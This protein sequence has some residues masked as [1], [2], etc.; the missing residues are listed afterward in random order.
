MIQR[1][2]PKF[3]FL[4]NVENL[5]RHEK[6]S[7]FRT[8][9]NTLER[10]LGYKVIGVGYNLQGEPDYDPSDF[11]R[12][13]KEFGIP[14]NR[15]RVYIIAFNRRYFGK[16]L[17]LIPNALPCSR[18][19]GPLYEDVRDILEQGEIPMKFFLSEG[20]LETLEKH[21]IRQRGRGYGFGM[22]V[23]NDPSIAHPIASAILATGGSGR[24]RNLV[25]DVANGKRYAGQEAKGKFSPI[26]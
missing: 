9:I 17:D 19:G 6:G 20:Y 18:P 14:Q 16:H 15:P 21:K 4:E 8:I 23:V 22:K 2:Q 5:V 25:L 3:V 24:E 10:E 13:S 12:N 7:T 11:V 26:N 1:T